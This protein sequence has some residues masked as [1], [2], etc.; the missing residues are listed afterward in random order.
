MKR[1]DNALD[2]LSWRG[3]LPFSQD[4]FNEIDMLLF[5]M[6]VYA[7]IE[8]YAKDFTAESGRGPTLLS[9][10][11]TVYPKPLPK[12]TS[13]VFQPRYD[14]WHMMEDHKR[15]AEV[16]LDRFLSNFEPEN[17]KQFAAAVFCCIIGGRK[18]AVVSFRGTDATVTGWKEDFDMA[19]KSPIPAQ[20]DALEFL[21]SVLDSG[22]DRIY[23][24]GHSKGLRHAR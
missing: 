3:D 16:H 15:F 17:D 13:Y 23:S 19:Y 7:P 6:L 11:R 9:L 22:Y 5:S 10:F 2:Y 20:S 12:G 21:N 18:V 1:S 14:L 24:A 8:N 4:G